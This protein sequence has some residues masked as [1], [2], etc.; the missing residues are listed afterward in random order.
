MGM[1]QSA[2]PINEMETF[3]DLL[4]F[5]RRR[6]RIS[7]REL[8]IALGYS[9][10]HLSRLES[11][12]RRP[13][14]SSLLALFVPALGIAEEPETVRLLLQLA[15]DVP[16]E[17]IPIHT[18]PE[19]ALS[20]PD[21]LTENR[22]HLPLQM[23]SFVG[24]ET[25]LADLGRLLS[26]PQTRLV[27]LTGEGGCG[28]TRL[29]LR[30]G[31]Q[32][33]GNF[34]N[35]AWLVELA[36]LSDDASVLYTACAALGVV[37]R[38]GRPAM[39]DLI[40]FLRSK[41]IL[42][43]LDNCE[44]MVEESARFSE[45]LLRACPRLKILATSRESLG[46]VGEMTYR[47]QPLS[48]PAVQYGASLDS[49]M[50][51][52]G[53][54]AVRLFVE[55]GR[56]I[57]HAFSLTDQNAAAVARICLRLDGIPLAIELAA[58][59]LNVLH[60]EQI[61][62]RLEGSFDLL[63]STGRSAGPRHHQTLRTAIDW[64]YH[65][66]DEAERSLLRH[67]AIFENGWSLEAA[68]WI[69]PHAQIP[70]KDVLVLLASLVNKSLVCADL[71]GEN[72]ARYRML[73]TIRSYLRE[74]LVENQEERQVRD[75][76]LDFFVNL[77]EQADT[78]VKGANQIQWLNLLNRER[79]NLRTALSWCVESGNLQKGLRLASNLGGYWWM[80]GNNPEGVRWYQIFREA[81]EAAPSLRSN[82]YTA[83]A[84]S[85]YGL[86]LD[87]MGS[88][89]VKKLLDESR[90][91]YQEL[92]DSAGMGMAMCWRGAYEEDLAKGCAI[93]HQGLDYC[94]QAEDSWWIAE[95]LH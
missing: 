59:R 26:D 18:E 46:L 50:V 88:P 11:N 2:I 25:D 78:G 58:A 34:E 72:Q 83:K 79:E 80:I 30:A 5:L 35:G 32:L 76:H 61:A 82:P 64:S 19:P 44:H 63:V 93:M 28:K 1:K 6:A 91:I 40:A 68:E 90:S 94:Y 22:S 89:L 14:R 43:I 49:A 62:G 10:S 27:T 92:G 60:P 39:V 38:E 70:G 41:D 8:S 33:A 3:G 67:L 29:A 66:L 37:S 71:A 47:V 21:S 31:E 81:V 12:Q 57:Q 51:S 56:G 84:F 42:L 9:E 77:S 69:V 15:E 85:Y 7:Q 75:G 54:E 45:G 20:T 87:S 23:S 65:L 36:P 24:R 13:D 74:K 17:P 95:T 48:L 16:V 86:L 52:A 55:R 4:K 73:E 53:S